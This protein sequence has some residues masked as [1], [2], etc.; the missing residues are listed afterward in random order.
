MKGILYTLLMMGDLAKLL[1]RAWRMS[2]VLSAHFTFFTEEM[3]NKGYYTYDF[4]ARAKSYPGFVAQVAQSAESLH[5]VVGIYGR[6]AEPLSSSTIYTNHTVQRFSRLCH[7]RYKSRIGLSAGIEIV[8]VVTL[9]KHF[10]GKEGGVGWQ[11]CA[12]MISS[13][14]A[15]NS[16]REHTANY[17]GY[18]S[19]NKPTQ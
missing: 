12:I 1:I 14:I 2:G 6:R 15:H 16:K 11:P 3:L 10:F 13:N 19:C 17:K 9:I 8:G 4:D 5:S 7:L 18:N